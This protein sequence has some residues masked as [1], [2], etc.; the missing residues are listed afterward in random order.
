MNSNLSWP[1]NW[2]RDPVI[3]DYLYNQ[4]RYHIAQGYD[5]REIANRLGI[6]VKAVWRYRQRHGIKQQFHAT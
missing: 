5:D 2:N 3:A 4:I 6:N 1:K